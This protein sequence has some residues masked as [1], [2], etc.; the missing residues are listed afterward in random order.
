MSFTI[1]VNLDEKCKRC[2]KA[3]ATQNGLCMSCNIKDIK[4]KIKRRLKSQGELVEVKND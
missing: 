2:G 4:E 1:H 3:G